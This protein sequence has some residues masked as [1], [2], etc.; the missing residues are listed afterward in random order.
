MATPKIHPADPRVPHSGA[1]TSKPEI[2]SCC[3]ARIWECF[4]TALATLLRGIAALFCPCWKASTPLPKPTPPVKPEPLPVTPPPK[5]EE[6]ASPAPKAT[7]PVVQQ[8]IA[9]PPKSA[10]PPKSEPL[11]QV[12]PSPAAPIPSAPV[13][14]K[15]VVT[16][17]SENELTIPVEKV[18][19]VLLERLNE[20]SE[21][22][23]CVAGS[24]VPIKKTSISP[25]L[26]EKTDCFIQFLGYELRP[27][28]KHLDEHRV[29]LNKPL[30][31]VF[32]QIHRDNTPAAEPS[33]TWS[34]PPKYVFHFI[35]TADGVNGNSLFQ[36]QRE[37]AL[38]AFF[39][40]ELG[41]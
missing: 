17:I 22:Y 10:T 12:E 30:I 7:P 2:P 31:L 38:C 6:A 34:S 32:L 16:F 8:P 19:G 20:K 5:E 29:D 25:E 13:K 36:Q 3:I 40:K 11:K 39:Y 14:R 28:W 26:F 27:D 41:I 33:I 4:K 15:V 24:A 18:Q 9:P 37:Q 23:D 1:S 21:Q 35:G